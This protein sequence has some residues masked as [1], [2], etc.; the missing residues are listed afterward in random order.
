MIPKS[1]IK[2]LA[3]YAALN[4]HDKESVDTG[5]AALMRAGKVSRELGVYQTVDKAKP[6]G[7][8]DDVLPTNV[9][10]VSG[11][12]NLNS[13]RGILFDTLDGLRNGTMNNERAKAIAA[14]SM[15][16]LKS[17]EVQMAVTREVRT[18]QSTDLLESVGQM[19]LVDESKK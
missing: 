15:T 9:V 11:D 14:V 2:P 5:I 18:S 10:I 4:R 17:V 1:G 6:N 3:L 8:A 12:K 7:K 19:A 13:V 16:I